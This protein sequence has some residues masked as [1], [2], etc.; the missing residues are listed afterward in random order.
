MLK[1][2]RY[3]YAIM[4]SDEKKVYRRIYRGLENHEESIK[5]PLGL[6]QQNV[7]DIYFKVLYDNPLF[8][9]MKPN[10]I[11]LTEILGFK[12]LQ[13]SYIYS[14]HDIEAIVRDVKKIINKMSHKVDHFRDN[15]LR[16]EKFLHDSL[17]KSVAYDYDALQKIECHNAH[18]I[19]GAFLEK[20][21]VCEGIS[22]AFK[23]LCNEFGIKCIMVVGYADKKGHFG[24]D[25]KHAWNLVKIKNESYHIDVT[26]DNLYDTHRSRVV[27]DYFNIS[28]EDIL[29][30]HQPT[31]APLPI[32][33]SNRLNY[34]NYTKSI[35]YTY[36][37]LLSL[38]IE[39]FDKKEIMLKLKRNQGEFIS[40]EEVKAKIVNALKEAAHIY[41]KARSYR[42]AFNETQNIVR[43]T[44]MS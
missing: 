21:A 23:L 20:K 37:E 36:E 44:F 10:T 33:K 12:W 13:P 32:C 28:T 40:I 14:C 18:S 43:I 16:I 42:F 30:D 6:P 35:V 5:I 39:R 3:Y 7:Q 34:F 17:V 25:N 2:D 41:G 8:F 24:N 1:N 4:N 29:L 31:A 19:V 27:Y 9:Y 26:W 11:N 15:Q 22:K 38:V